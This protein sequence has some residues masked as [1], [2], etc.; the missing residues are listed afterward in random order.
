MA[1]AGERGGRAARLAAIKHDILVHLAEPDLSVAGV[2]G[3]QRLSPRYIHKL[4]EVDGT[5]YSEF[6]VS[7][8]LRQA[9]RLLTDPRFG[10]DSIGAI[11][12]TVGFGDLSYFNR[13]F[14]RQFGMTPSEVRG[15]VRRG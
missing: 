12:L 1:I 4:F 8:R 10:H 15:A 3:R 13:T 6:V 11:A 9:H 14:R 5:T 7:Q 2:A